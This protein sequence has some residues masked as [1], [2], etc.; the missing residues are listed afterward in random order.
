MK[1]PYDISMLTV[2]KGGANL[3]LPEV[4]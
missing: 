3:L 4:G 1:K 2:V